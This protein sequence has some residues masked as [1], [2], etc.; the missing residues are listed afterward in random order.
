[1][2]GSFPAAAVNDATTLLAVIADPKAAQ[3]R[4]DAINEAHAKLDERV[5][6]LNE[7][8][9]KLSAREAAT[10]AAELAAGKKAHDLA[11][12]AASLEK[13][14]AD[15]DAQRATFE[16]ERSK[17][18]QE[19]TDREELLDQKDTMNK[20]AAAKQATARAELEQDAITLQAIR[21]GLEAR[22]KAVVEGEGAL[23]EKRARLTQALQGA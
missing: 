12:T 1:M 15:L 17:R 20:Q 22:E 5:R 19:L 6:V 3:A 14:K 8:E 4:L 2:M 23:K 18:H 9:T 7:Y 10:Q 21:A 13:D 11:V 16:G